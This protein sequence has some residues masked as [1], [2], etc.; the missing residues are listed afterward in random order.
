MNGFTTFD[1]ALGQCAIAWRG[2]AVTGFMLPGRNAERSI[3]QK[4]TGAEPGTPPAVIAAVIAQALRYFD[5]AE[6]D[7]T[8]VDLDLS[9]QDKFRRQVYD[10]LRRVGWGATTTYGALAREVGGGPETARD[11]GQAMA[12]NPVPLIIPCHRVL[13]AGN[14]LGGFSA[15]GGTAS[16]ERMLALEGVQTGP[17]QRALGL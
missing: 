4:V 8:A 15:P 11:V 2:A 13:A 16:K 7:F 3:R 9:G 1:T 5:G 14:K 6:E 12:N 17:A 10:A